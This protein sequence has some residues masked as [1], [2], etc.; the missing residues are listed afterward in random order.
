MPTILLSLITSGS[1]KWLFIF[2]IIAGLTGGLY[3]K[4][5][6]I[7]DNEKQIAL[8]EYNIKQLEQNLKEKDVYIK[9]MEDINKHKSEI[10]ANLYIERDKLE[11]KLKNTV[12]KIDRHVG[13]GHDRES[14]QI[15]KDTIRSL[16]E[17][18]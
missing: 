4:H 2:L 10:V 15:L 13:A 6:E 11:E 5:R 9:Q 1:V 18:K 16:E 12:S 8:Q 17:M 7:V 14:S 3:M